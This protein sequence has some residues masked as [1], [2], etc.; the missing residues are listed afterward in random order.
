VPLV[1]GKILAALAAGAT[2]RAACAF[3]EISEATFSNWLKEFFE[4][5]EQVA[6]AEGKAEFH[7]TSALAAAAGQDWR[8]AAFWLKHRRREE[9]HERTQFEGELGIRPGG[10]SISITPDEV[11]RRVKEI[12]GLDPEDDSE[13]PPAQVTQ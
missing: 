12:Y 2:R 9:W 5:S 7:Y 11:N 1:A 6:F 4:F 10:G 3:A 13:E 8:A